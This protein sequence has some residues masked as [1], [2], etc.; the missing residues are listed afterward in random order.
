MCEVAADTDRGIPQRPLPCTPK[1]KQNIIRDLPWTD[2]YRR[3]K[4][5]ACA[6]EVVT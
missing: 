6:P 2:L 1:E 4:Y 3:N 5:V